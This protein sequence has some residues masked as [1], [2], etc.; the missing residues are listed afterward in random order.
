MA[1]Q[2]IL[3]VEDDPDVREV[4][5][6]V[7]ES[8]GFSVVAAATAR[9]A[10]TAAARDSIDAVLIDLGLPDMDGRELALHLQE[11]PVAILT[12][13]DVDVVIPGASMVLQ[14]PLANEQLIKAVRILISTAGYERSA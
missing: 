12:G 5:S 10:L 2:R 9:D 8:H 14:K 3:L 6:C 1:I 13:G 11:Y 4:T 7:L